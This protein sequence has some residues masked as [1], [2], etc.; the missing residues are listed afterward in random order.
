[1][2][3]L[4]NMSWTDAEALFKETDVALLPVGSTEQHGP[5]NPLG[6]DHLVAAA[7]SRRVG[8]RTGVPVLPVIPVGVSEHHRQFTGTLW[9]PPSVFREY[10]K[11]VALSVASHGVR[12]I[13]FVNGHGGNTAAL[14]EVAGE[15]RRRHGIFAAVVSAFPPILGGHAG[16]DETS[17]NLY[18]HGHLVRMERAVDTV[19]KESLGP[20]KMEGLN[21]IGPARFPWDTIDLTET[22]VLGSAGRLIEST[23]A[24]EEHGRELMEPYIEEVIKFVEALKKA[25]VE[26]LLSKPHK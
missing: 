12:K 17:V 10:M 6:T 5:H 19:Q 22:G 4:A 25:R 15:L 24:S 7:L 21:R 1:M 2:V 9:V 14:V 23:T 8:D 18:F 20:L 13:L 26:Q 3:Q 11:A 16:A